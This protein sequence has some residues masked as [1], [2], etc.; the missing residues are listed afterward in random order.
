MFTFDVI[1]R[2]WKLFLIDQPTLNDIRSYEKNHS[3][4][5]TILQTF[6]LI[7]GVASVINIK[8]VVKS[9]TMEW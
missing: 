6:V 8:E 9:Y 7:G 3:T 4:I 1:I 5:C 2:Q